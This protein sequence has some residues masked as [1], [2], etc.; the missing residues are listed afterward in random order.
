[1]TNYKKMMGLACY[2]AQAHMQDWNKQDIEE[3]VD[4]CGVEACIDFYKHYQYRYGIDCS[5]VLDW[6]DEIYFKEMED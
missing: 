5:R 3:M 4:N 1:M 6:L 2:I